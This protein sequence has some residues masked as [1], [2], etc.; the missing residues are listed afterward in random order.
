[1]IHVLTYS[2]VGGHR[3]NEDAFVAR[4]HPVDP[5]SWLICL[6][7]GQGGRAGGERAAKLACETAA[8]L[9]TKAPAGDLV[10]SSAWQ[11]ILAHA[12]ATVAADRA[13]GFTT[14]IGLGILTNQIG[15]ASS[16][17]SAA[18]LFSGGKALELSAR[19]FKNPPVG[20]GEATFIPFEARAARPWRLL[21]MSDGVWKYAGWE[22]VRKLATT[23]T[24]PELLAQLQDA[25][26]LRGTGA[27][28]DDFT[29]ILVEASD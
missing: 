23:M 16:G 14:L 15:G 28:P 2:E 17:D 7:D 18:V 1:M 29:V 21:A 4:P 6:A 13:A 20:S 24:G 27:F 26:R 8:D 19:Q 9:A 12:D 10:N 25:A 5:D 22:M 11:S 3:V